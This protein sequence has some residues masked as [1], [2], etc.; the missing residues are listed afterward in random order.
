M[1]ISIIKK[2]KFWFVTIGIVALLSFLYGFFANPYRLKNTKQVES[3][4]RLLSELERY[5]KKD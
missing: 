1:N 3:L 4:E 2:N 5:E